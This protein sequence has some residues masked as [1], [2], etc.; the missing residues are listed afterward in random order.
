MRD[1]AVD[2]IATVVKVAVMNER[3]SIMQLVCEVALGLGG[4]AIS[5]YEMRDELIEKIQARD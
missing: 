3:A 2:V 4:C 5:S 1:E